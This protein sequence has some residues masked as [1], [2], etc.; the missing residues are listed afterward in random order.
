[1]GK[2]IKFKFSNPS[3]FVSL[4]SSFDWYRSQESYLHQCEDLILNH[5]STSFITLS[6][7]R[8]TG[9]TSLEIGDC[10]SSELDNLR[11]TACLFMLSSIEGTLRRDLMCRVILNLKDGV[12]KSLIGLFNKARSLHEIPIG[13]KT[14][15]LRVWLDH[16]PDQDDCLRQLARYYVQRNWLAHGR[17]NWS[18]KIMGKFSPVDIYRLGSR[19]L[20]ELCVDTSGTGA[21]LERRVDPS[22]FSSSNYLY[23]S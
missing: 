5:S 1:M 2:S 18:P 8:F 21:D 20:T 12:S 19:V 11:A 3:D 9:L 15:I 4:E 10:F 13:L 14:G 7:S 22:Y 23:V 16:S 17:Y 6:E